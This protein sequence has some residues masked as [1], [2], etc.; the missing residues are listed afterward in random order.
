MAQRWLSVMEAAQMLGVHPSQ[1]R[2]DIIAGRVISRF[3]ESGRMVLVGQPD[4]ALPAEDPH[5]RR[6]LG[7]WT[8]I[9]WMIAGILAV[10][11]SIVYG[12]GGG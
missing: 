2:H 6:R 3:D 12:M 9:S 1:V 10:L 11:A 4:G 7:R 5:L 8:W